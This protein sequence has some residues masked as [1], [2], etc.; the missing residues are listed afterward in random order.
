M[1]R[2]ERGPPADWRS[3]GLAVEQF[4]ERGRP[5]VRHTHVEHSDDV[6]VVERRGDP[7]F[8]QEPFDRAPIAA[9]R[10]GERLERDVSIEPRIGSPG[11][12]LPFRHEP[13]ASRSGT[14]RPGAV[15]ERGSSCARSRAARTRA[16]V[17]RYP[18]AATGGGEL[19]GHPQQVRVLSGEEALDPARCSVGAVSHVLCHSERT[20]QRSVFIVGLA[21]RACDAA[22]RAPYSSR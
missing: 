2:P 15:G 5:T 4:R 7:R 20:R 16:G 19:V 1:R 6:G 9:L 22:R 13:A 11:R 10:A 14:V 17:S 8:L 18:R 21:S 12:R 3:Q